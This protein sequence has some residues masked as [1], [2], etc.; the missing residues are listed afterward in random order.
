[1]M[2]QLCPSFLPPPL[3]WLWLYGVAARWGICGGQ[4]LGDALCIRRLVP[5]S[6]YVFARECH[7]LAT[8]EQ[9]TQLAPE[10]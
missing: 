3:F 7:I 9:C 1:M 2:G 6:F 10:Q 8:H 5:V 4:P